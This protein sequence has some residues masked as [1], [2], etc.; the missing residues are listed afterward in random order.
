MFGHQA[1][2][3]VEQVQK[4]AHAGVSPFFPAAEGS[5]RQLGQYCW[6]IPPD[7]K[8]ARARD[9]SGALVAVDLTYPS[10]ARQAASVISNSACLWLIVP[11]SARDSGGR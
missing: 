6:S 2:R 10:A 11:L 7:S 5:A 1:S 3:L 8:H 9:G 4:G